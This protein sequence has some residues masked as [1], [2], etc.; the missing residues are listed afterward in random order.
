MTIKAILGTARIPRPKP[1]PAFEIPINTKAGTAIMQNQGSL[2]NVNG[3]AASNR[4]R[5]QCYGKPSEIK[6][7]LTQ[8]AFSLFLLLLF[9]AIHG[10]ELL[11]RWLGCIF[12]VS[13]RSGI[14]AIC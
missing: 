6:L 11:V 8:L 13:V 4:D 2:I 7:G 12:L 9:Y 14:I 5:K 1:N 3:M 10:E